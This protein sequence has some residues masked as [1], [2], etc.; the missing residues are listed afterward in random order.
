[1]APEEIIG[2]FGCDLL[3][4]ENQITG[5]LELLGVAGWTKPFECVG[6]VAE[7]RLALSLAAARPEWRDS[8]VVH[9]IRRVAPG[10]LVEP[11]GGLSDAL[12][13]SGE[14]LVPPGYA[15]CERDIC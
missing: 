12:R 11:A 3:D 2:I 13:L 15:Q 8:A 14:D 7:T 5:Y 9:T 10:S 4:D 6:D 1:L